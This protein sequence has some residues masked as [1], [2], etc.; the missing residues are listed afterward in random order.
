M[1][2]SQIYADTCSEGCKTNAKHK[3]TSSF[4]FDTAT[5]KVL[6]QSSWIQELGYVSYRSVHTLEKGTPSSPQLLSA[7]TEEQKKVLDG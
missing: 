7:E 5:Y 3:T 1:D 2:S 6:L 4:S